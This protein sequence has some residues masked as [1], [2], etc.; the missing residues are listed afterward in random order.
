LTFPRICDTLY[1]M[2]ADSKITIRIEVPKDVFDVYE[3]QSQQS[4]KSVENLMAKRLEN[5]KWYTSMNPIYLDDHFRNKLESLLSRSIKSA[6]DLIDYLSSTQQLRLTEGIRISLPDALLKRIET[7]RFGWPLEK[8]I[9]RE[10][11]HGLE[12]YVGLR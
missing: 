6:K 3:R 7:R 5:C 11:I 12:T 9:E 2:K 1:K 10:A 8:V 4:G